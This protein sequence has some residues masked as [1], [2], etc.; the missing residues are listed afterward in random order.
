M[1]TSS[2]IL[3]I[4]DDEAN[5]SL[6]AHLLN[7]HDVQAQNVLDGPAGLAKAA[8]ETPDLILLD[9]FMPEMDGFA[10][11]KVLKANKD[12]QHIPVI[13]MSIIEDENRRQQALEYGAAGFFPKPFDLQELIGLVLERLSNGQA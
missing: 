4:D 10:V 2:K 11:L 9:V 12:L 5:G 3:I 7:R 13:M 6:L 8:D 1:S